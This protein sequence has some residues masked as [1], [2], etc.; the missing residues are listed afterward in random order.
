MDF[1]N[2]IFQM[3]LT[4]SVIFLLYLI[5]KPLTKK[6]FNSSWHY[7]ML[8]V[9]LCFF[10]L[11]IDSYLQLPVRQ[12]ARIPKIRIEESIF[13]Q[14][15]N[16]KAERKNETNPINNESTANEV[17]ISEKEANYKERESN[18]FG[19]EDNT[20]LNKKINLYP[21]KNLLL[22]F[23]LIG[24]IALFLLKII[25]YLAFKRTM[26]KSSSFVKNDE[27]IQLF[28]KCKEELHINKKLELRIYKNL[29][30]P[31]LIGILHPIV[32]IPK[33]DLGHKGLELVFLHELNHY[34]RK[35]I[36]IKTVGLFAHAM[37]WFNPL[38]Y[39][40]LKEMN[41]YCE[42]SVD[43]KVVEN[44][45]K[46]DR[47]FYGEMIINLISNS[48]FRNCSLTTAMSNGG[49][50]LKDRLE[51]MFY[52]LKTT[53]KRQFMSFISGIIIVTCGFTVAYSLF[54]DNQWK[55]EK[56]FVVYTK[57][58]GLYYSY[59]DMQAEIK[60]D[61]GDDFFCPLISKGGNYIAYTKNNSLYI[62]SLRDSS[63]E[64]VDDDIVHHFTSYD[65]I[66][67]RSI[68]YGSQERYGFIL[69]NVI[70][71]EK[72]P[73]LEDA[74]Y[75]ALVASDQK[76]VYA[77]KS[78][79]ENGLMIYEG[80]VEIDLNQYS[81]DKQQ[82]FTDT[83]IKSKE[84]TKDGLDS[85]PVVW[86]HSQDGRY[87]YIMVIPASASLSSDGI[88]FAVYDSEEKTYK[89][90]PEIETL[91]YKNHLAVRPFANM[92]G[93][94]EGAGREMSRNK[95]VKIFNI[96]GGTVD[97]TDEDFVAMT[98]SFTLDGKKILYSAA[99]TKDFNDI[100]FN[101][102]IPAFNI[103]E[104]DL[105]SS[106]IQRLTEGNH[107][108][109]LPMDLSNQ[110]ILFIRYKDNGYFSLIKLSDGQE[111]IFADNIVFADAKESFGYYGH[112]STEMSLDIYISNR[113]QFNKNLKK[114]N[115]EPDKV[116][117][118]YELRGTYIGDNVRVGK[119]IRYLN[120]P[121]GL[122][123]NGMELFT[124]KEPYGLQINFMADEGAKKKYMSMNSDY[125]WRTQSLILFSLIHNLDYI[126]Y[127]IDD[128]NSIEIIFY[129]DRKD[130]DA[131]SMSL[132]SC[133]SSEIA[134]SPESF[135]Q[136]YNILNSNDF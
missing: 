10:I 76:K 113:D 62:Y 82:F 92:V 11:P 98:P 114:E 129:T 56:S 99:D 111:E 34:K 18:E 107:F 15:K 66:D 20:I 74:Y 108:D 79:S 7:K 54:A 30:S 63:L 38:I 131:L 135:R 110:Q 35:D 77:S 100:I 122:S 103:Y 1:L 112:I 67:D 124:K 71:K 16:N 121:E 91:A 2:K 51:N 133:K 83:I 48:A 96:S 126:Q 24:V 118:L 125:I 109:F 134:E 89:E 136:Y 97:I 73:H 132:M 85:Y 3:S 52:S 50:Q 40:L 94:I 78:R 53:R 31:M 8:I 117:E 9:F 29:A 49:R 4:G 87:L 75:T 86:N 5:F 88:T 55:N 27:V 41:K 106:I 119:I 80:I 95:K 13:P 104:Y 44:M 116:D 42:Y 93:L 127:A 33:T 28:D 43:E 39:L 128:G 72:T 81:K 57:E 47:K 115:S 105:K 120:F 32:L 19:L 17:H 6:L 22:Y 46:N 64:K 123:S 36:I 26:L 84:S 70:T 12:F 14:S 21:Y 25:P 59:L 60:I 61:D 65:W 130:A 101:N 45:D 69:Y 68:V 102:K 23:W 58:D 37:H 90:Y